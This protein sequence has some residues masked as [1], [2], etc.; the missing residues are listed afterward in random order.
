MPVYGLYNTKRVQSYET[1][2]N[3]T[4]ATNGFLLWLIFNGA[5]N[6][7]QYVN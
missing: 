1:N 3:N 5:F 6:L 4:Q 2:I 7:S